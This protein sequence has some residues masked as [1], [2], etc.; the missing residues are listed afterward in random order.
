VRGADEDLLGWERALMAGESEAAA[1]IPG[2]A[3]VRAR[4]TTEKLLAS[5]VRYRV[6]FESCPLALIVYEV[7]NLQIL[8]VNEA[9]VQQYGHSREE[10]ARLTIR[11]LRPAADQ[12]RLDE[13]LQ[14]M[15]P[16]SSS[17]VPVR[18]RHLRK[19]GTTFDVEVVWHAVDYE[20][21]E[22]RL[23]L[24]TDV[25]ERLRAEA[26]LRH[27]AAI[28]ESTDDAVIS[29]A[30]D[31]TILTWNP[32]ASWIYGYGMHEV[33]GR[34][35]SMLWPPEQRGEVAQL[36]ARLSCGESIYQFET[37][38]L[39]KGGERRQVLLTLSP[40]RDERGHIAGAVTITRDVTERLRLE[41]ELRQAQK[42]E[43][44][45][46]LAGGVAHDFNNLLTTILGYSELLLKQTAEGGQA[47]RWA[48][49]VHRA[50]E[51]AAA[52]TRQMLAFSRRQRLQTRRIAINDVVS[53]IEE[54][55]RRLIGENI[56]LATRLDGA[57]GSVRADPVQLDQVI[58]NLV[59]NS[60]DALPHGGRVTITTA[61]VAPD[62]VSRAALPARPW[63][64]LTVG[65]NGIGMEE[66]VRIHLFEPF[67]TTKEVGKG[68]GL[69]LSTVY[70]IV[71]QSGGHIRVSSEPGEGTR[72]DL[73]LP[74]CGAGAEPHLV[75]PA[76]GAPTSGR[77]TVLLVEDDDNLRA[78]AAEILS[79][80]EY[81]VVT[82]RD[83]A[84]A[85]ELA[86]Q[87]PET[88][89]LLLTDVI[90]PGITGPELARRLRAL[91]AGV[92]VLMVSGYAGSALFQFEPEELGSHFLQ[93]PFRPDELLQRVREA[94]DTE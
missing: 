48:T 58:M 2:H 63:V 74:R 11:A 38:C 21:R 67:F 61:P 66:E 88:I 33:R 49:E 65:D 94:L 14:S 92:K 68:T 8:A 25:T 10:F 91:H 34:S 87:A 62:E 35:I 90:M 86:R 42:M 1:S 37:T 89:D 32:A 5:E 69:G 22:S 41:S 6:L 15:A 19:D 43:A 44:I 23:S 72:F 30:P 31:G 12:Q 64:R 57:A 85:L 81:Q 93:K 39:H 59:I 29:F 70:G 71:S 53:G 26:A 45:G 80:S 60:R 78:L 56:E 9:A 18:V 54:M 84:E 20:G 13:I 76:A 77:E 79:G 55:L 52:L 7:H 73:Y 4:R 24:V 50:G 27:M 47:Q 28:V 3:P 83:A 36:L 51:R 75:A 82:A 40:L 17:T 16:S 46:R